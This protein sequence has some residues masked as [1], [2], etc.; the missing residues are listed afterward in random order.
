M[1]CLFPHKEGKA[2]KQAVKMS[3]QPLPELQ[4]FFLFQI[5]F[6]FL[7]SLSLLY[8]NLLFLIFS[9]SVFFS[10]SSSLSFFFLS[11]VASV[12][13]IC[14]SHTVFFHFLL[15]PMLH[16]EAS[17]NPSPSQQW[18]LGLCWLWLSCQQCSEVLIEAS[19]VVKPNFSRWSTVPV[20]LSWGGWSGCAEKL[21]FSKACALPSFI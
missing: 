7:F 4:L 12:L 9:H 14:S 20:Q 21:G 5:P 8:P 18:P 11:I 6:T 19:G 13:L 2:K 17:E 3:S 15:F 16:W 1:L 10:P